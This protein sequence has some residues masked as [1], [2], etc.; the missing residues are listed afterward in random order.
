MVWLIWFGFFFFLKNVVNGNGIMG[1]FV[2][3]VLIIDVN[4]SG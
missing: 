2:S 1:G 3:C 4:I